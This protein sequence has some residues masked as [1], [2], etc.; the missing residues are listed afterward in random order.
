LKEKTDQSRNDRRSSLQLVDL[1][2]RVKNR[3]VFF[4]TPFE[5][6]VSLF[7]SNENNSDSKRENFFL[8]INSTK[9]KIERTKERVGVNNLQVLVAPI[10]KKF[11]RS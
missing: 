7:V 2:R 3:E 5:G 4:Q 9:K 8:N 11:E 1:D 10:D 6:H